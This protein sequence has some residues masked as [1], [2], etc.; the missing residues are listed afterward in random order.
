MVTMVPRLSTDRLTG[1]GGVSVPHEA[2]NVT[3]ITTKAI[4]LSIKRLLL[5]SAFFIRMI[6]S[7]IEKTYTS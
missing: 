3:E 4:N 6:D 7:V 2:N 1:S 5:H